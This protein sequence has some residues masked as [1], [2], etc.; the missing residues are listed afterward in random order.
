ME[1]LVARVKRRGQIFERSSI[2]ATV[3]A[4]RRAAKAAT[5]YS[6]IIAI[7]ASALYEEV[8]YDDGGDV[9]LQFLHWR[10]VIHSAA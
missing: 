5:T 7:F 10:S 2:Q 6:G 1:T 9:G 4:N 3:H 8:I